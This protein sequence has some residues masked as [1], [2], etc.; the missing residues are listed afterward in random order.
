MIHQSRESPVHTG[1]VIM[2]ERVRPYRAR[3]VPGR[4]ARSGLRWI[5]S[6]VALIFSAAHERGSLAVRLAPYR[7]TFIPVRDEVDI[8]DEVVA[9]L[10]G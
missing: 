10:T 8:T 1:C 3:T 5:E 9:R 7:V 4:G 2:A 6:P